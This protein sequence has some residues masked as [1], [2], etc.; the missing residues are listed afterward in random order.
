MTK[1][2]KSLRIQFTPQGDLEDPMGI[3]IEQHGDQ[4]HMNSMNCESWND[5]LDS[6]YSA[7]EAIL[8]IYKDVEDGKKLRIEYG[9]IRTK[10]T[11]EEM[12]PVYY[13]WFIGGRNFGNCAGD[14]GGPFETLEDAR[15][16]ADAIA[17][18]EGL[19]VYQAA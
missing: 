5:A 17:V 10:W 2:D 9:P 1:P 12:K 8:D 4:V 14:F 13:F 7:M 19:G 18:K 15:V 3:T 16:S 11:P 6:A